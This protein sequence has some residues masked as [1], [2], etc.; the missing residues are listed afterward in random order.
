MNDIGHNSPPEPFDF[1]EDK[2]NALY[3]EAKHWLDGEE[4]KD[5]KTAEGVTDLLNLLRK[6]NKEAD[7]ERKKEKKP[8]DDLGKAVQEKYKPL[9]DKAE[10]AATACKKAL[11]PFL[12]AKEKAKQEEAERFRMEAEVKLKDA[13]D[14]AIKARGNNLT[15]QENASSLADEA[16]DAAKVARKAEN[17]SSNTKSQFGRAAGLR[18]SYAT[19]LTDPMEAIRHYWPD[20]SINAV[21]VALAKKD[22]AKGAREIPGFEIKEE[23]RAV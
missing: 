1:I 4:V 18:T 17:A 21:L 10:L 5:E 20:D 7:E 6:S 19:T 12:I 13:Q 2:I 15:E 3:E 9:T 22:V 16:Q 14:A 11:A 8:H 23:K